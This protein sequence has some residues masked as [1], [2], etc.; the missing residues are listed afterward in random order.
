M[1]Y[2]ESR[3]KNEMT[4]IEKRLNPSSLPFL[5]APSTACVEQVDAFSL[6][7]PE[8]FDL[9]AKVLYARAVREGYGLRWARRVYE[10]H[11]RVFNGIMEADT[12]GKDS[13]ASFEQ[14]FYELIEAFEKSGFDEKLSLVPVNQDSVLLDGAH[15]A[16]ACLVCDKPLTVARFTTD[17][18]VY[19]WR[20]FG[21]RG[22]SV[23]VSD[24]IAV[25]YCRQKRN[26]YVVIIY[27]AAG[28]DLLAVDRIL[29]EE[30]GV[31]YQ[32]TFSLSGDG[33]YNL[34]R[35]V[36]PDEKWLGNYRNGYAGA[37]RKAS[38]CFPGWAGDVKVYLFDAPSLKDAVRVKQ[39][40]REAYQV[41]NHSIHTNDTPEES[42]YLAQILFN[43]NSIWALNN[44]KFKPYEAFHESF[45]RYLHEG[46]GE[47]SC[48]GVNSLLAIAGVRP[49]SAIDRCDEELICSD[50]TMYFHFNGA[51]FITP[52]AAQEQMPETDSTTRSL[53]GDLAI[54]CVKDKVY[55]R[56]RLRRQQ[57]YYRLLRLR[58]ILRVDQTY[59]LAMRLRQKFIRH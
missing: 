17:S 14:V 12:S 54:S 32:K 44:L 52:W 41:E 20:F 49:A 6:L 10:D 11:L 29:E 50:P 42:L 8:R 31:V 22:L 15:R 53:L 5:P 58:R 38:A 51:K 23:E 59:R 7:T 33:P 39:R 57:F 40:I 47:R 19:D 35:Q 45:S 37:L 36:Y 21:R 28:G 18:P 30:G 1:H 46:A 27:P 34:I 48:L 24:S 9:P 43:D 55:E 13:L 25:E 4:D 26:C 16:A 2:G 56:K 3:E